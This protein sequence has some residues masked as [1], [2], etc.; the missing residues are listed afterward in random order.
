M[1]APANKKVRATAIDRGAGADNS[2]LAETRR[3]VNN[4]VTSLRIL[5]AKLD[6]DAGVTD[7]NYS[8]LVIDAALGTAAPTVI[9]VVN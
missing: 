4:L 5:T 3:Q 6:L 2:E 9:D 1:A 7:V 8:T